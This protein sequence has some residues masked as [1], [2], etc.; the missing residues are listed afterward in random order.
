MHIYLKTWVI[1][2]S[3]KWSCTPIPWKF[4]ELW[5]F[6]IGMLLVLNIFHFVIFYWQIQCYRKTNIDY[7]IYRYLK[8]KFTHFEGL[9]NLWKQLFL[10]VPHN[11]LGL[12]LLCP[13][14]KDYYALHL[15]LIY[16]WLKTILICSSVFIQLPVKIR[17]VTS[18][19]PWI[20]LMN[21]I[22]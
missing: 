18:R 7:H 10:L 22:D 15:T 11:A 21:H 17:M 13:P 19:S 16:L 12:Y 20:H 2:A 8:L 4:I 6:I 3:N 14:L 5:S 1:Q 9:D